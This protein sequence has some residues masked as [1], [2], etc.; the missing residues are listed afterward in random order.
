MEAEL[1]TQAELSLEAESS[2][3]VALSWRPSCL[4][5][6][7]LSEA[8]LSCL[9]V[10]LAELSQRPNCPTFHGSTC[11]SMLSVSVVP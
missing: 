1:S 2:L 11:T 8:D 10:V 5:G 3:E 7:V 6:R 9:F 4:R